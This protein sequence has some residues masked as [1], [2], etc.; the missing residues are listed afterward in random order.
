MGPGCVLMVG[1]LA[2]LILATG[3]GVI[4]VSRAPGGATRRERLLRSI[5]WFAVPFLNVAWFGVAA[6]VY[7][8]AQ[9]ARGYS[10]IEPVAVPVGNGYRLA[11]PDQWQ[12]C[13]VGDD[14][15]MFEV[16][17]LGRDGDCVFGGKKGG[18][19]FVLD[20]RRRQR[21][22]FP[23]E[24]SMDAALHRRGV[25]RVRLQ[26]NYSYFTVNRWDLFDFVVETVV[27]TAAVLLNAFA[28]IVL[29]PLRQAGA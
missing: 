9:E 28:L 11:C 8:F 13:V 15:E 4:L 23:D 5:G 1:A 21:F 16:T 12:E 17:S 6:T 25:T 2:A 24:R 14:A 3:A 19:F 26:S 22:D 10:V 27:L 7:A 20:T 18:G 29:G